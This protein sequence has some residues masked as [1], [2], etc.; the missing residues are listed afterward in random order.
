MLK[1]ISN[2]LL[3]I[4]IGVIAG[5]G[6]FFFLKKTPKEENIQT[7]TVKEFIENDVVPSLDKLE[8]T[9][10]EVDPEQIILFNTQVNYQSVSMTI[11]RLN[12]LEAKG[13]NHVYIVLDSP[14]G[15]VIDGANLIAYMKASKMRI[16]TVCQ[17]ICASMAAQ[18][19]QVG[20]KRYMTDK[21]IL[22]FHPA[23]TRIGGKIEEMLNQL[24][25]IKKYVDRLD[26]EVAARAGIRYE[27][28]KQMLVSELW[29]ESVDAIEMGLAD[30]IAYLFNKPGTNPLIFNLKKATNSDEVNNANGLRDLQ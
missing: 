27:T 4:F 19:H 29:V 12:E 16:D 17:G 15:S 6:T 24:I 2:L 5:A 26:A 23:A 14:G 20:K 9:R 21:S 18:I 22:M 11:D 10:I 8:V 25:T 13:Y 28:F 7:P 30:E 1:K 3:I